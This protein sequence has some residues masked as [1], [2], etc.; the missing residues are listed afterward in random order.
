[1]RFTAQ[2]D[3]NFVTYVNLLGC[4]VWKVACIIAIFIC[5]SITLR[6]SGC[7]AGKRNAWGAVIF[8][9]ECRQALDEGNVRLFWSGDNKLDDT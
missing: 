2:T 8:P 9:F 4:L 6:G 3:W 7:Y 1:M 5:V